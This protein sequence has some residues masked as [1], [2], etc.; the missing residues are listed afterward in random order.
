MGPMQ[1][2]PEKM[3]AFY[4]ALD[5]EGPPALSRMPEVYAEELCFTDPI[6][7]HE[8][9]PSVR[10]VFERLFDKYREVRFPEITI[11]GHERHF[12][13]TWTMALTL[14]LGPTVTVRGASDFHA[15]DGLVYRQDDYYDVLGA[16]LGGVPV[17]GPGHL[18][19]LYRWGVRQIFL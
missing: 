11:V 13:G 6:Q 19:P 5:R 9:R 1:T 8:G 14:K 17:V 18:T 3:S 4:Q 7:R 15:R 2:L 16:A 10:A 12:M